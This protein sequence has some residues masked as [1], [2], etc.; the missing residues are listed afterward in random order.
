M[1]CDRGLHGI[2]I[3]SRRLQI[4]VA[5]PG[6][7]KMTSREI[8]PRGSAGNVGMTP[9]NCVSVFA[10][11][12]GGIPMTFRVLAK[13]RFRPLP[14]SIRT[15]PMLNPPIWAST[16]SAAWPGRG[17]DGG[18]LSRLK[19][20]AFLDQSTYSVAM[21]VSARLTSLVNFFI[22]LSDGYFLLL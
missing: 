9:W 10:K 16:T 21:Q 2:A 15:L 22:S 1:L 6:L 18:W 8:L 20:I 13:R 3:R 17:T 14:P 12:S 5:L 4:R 7:P 19:L 11:A